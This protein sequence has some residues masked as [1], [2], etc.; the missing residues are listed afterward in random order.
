MKN[1][2]IHVANKG[3]F[4]IINE[5][6]EKQYTPQ[7]MVTRLEDGGSILSISTDDHGSKTIVLDMQHTF[8]LA[9]FITGSRPS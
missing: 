3:D 5:H 1:G 4:I 7:M 9:N 6:V 2:V 8:I